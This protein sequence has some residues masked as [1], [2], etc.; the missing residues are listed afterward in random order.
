[1]FR[2]ALAARGFDEAFFVMADMEM[3]FHLLEQ[4]WFAYIDE[5]LCAFRTHGRQQTEKDRASLA[6]ALENRELLRRYLDRPY[7]RFRRWI[8]EY[9]EYDAVRRIVRRSRKLG[10]GAG[11]RRGG[12][13]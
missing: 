8:G 5:P 11:A 2:R 4:G 12:D 10:A 6:P 1:M 9:L 3:W 7:V 13:P